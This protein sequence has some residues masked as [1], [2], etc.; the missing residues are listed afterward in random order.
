MPDSLRVSLLLLSLALAGCQSLRPSPP[1]APPPPGASAEISGILAAILAEHPAPA[2]VASI[3][4]AD[5]SIETGAVGVRRLGRPERVTPDDRFH[6]GSVTKP[7]TATVI[8]T[9][10]D[11]GKLQWST[12]IAEALPECAATMRPDYK[13]VTLADLLAHEGGVPPFDEDE[14]IAAVPPL[15]GSPTAQR[16]AFSCFALS[17]PPVVKPKQAFS[18]SNAGFAVATAI[19]EKASGTSWEEMLKT[20]VFTPLGLT[21]AGLGWPAKGGAP[22]PWGHWKR[23]W[24]VVPQD[25]DGKYQLSAFIAPAGDVHMSMPDLARFLLAHLRAF[26]G[27]PK[28]LRPETARLMHTKR[29]QS[30]LGWGVQAL[31]GHDPVSAY[32]G[33]AD[34]FM[35]LV[36]I[37]H[38]AD[39]VIAVSANSATPEAEAATKLALKELLTRYG[40]KAAGG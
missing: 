17:Q 9:L 20:R 30:G 25:P 35:T 14:Q 15:N 12:T 40:G 7:M 10:V 19:A 38:D 37:V 26:D 11:E 1:P 34:T 39:L 24:R 22:Q 32:Q 8:A 3:G 33:S 5:G 29:I 16:R 27:D 36:A 21:T 4:H 23:F 31:L 6:V 13:D 28:L 2:L 18:Y